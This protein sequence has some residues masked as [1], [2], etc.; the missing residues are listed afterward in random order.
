MMPDTI[1]RDVLIHAPQAR[2]WSALTEAR[3]L[4]S[5]F[6]DAGAEVELRL[7]GRVRIDWREHGTALG[8]VEELDPPHAFGFR[9]SLIS[10]EPPVPGNSTLVRFTLEPEGD[11]H[12]RLR[13]VESGFRSLDGDATE[14]RR[15]LEANEA[16]W[17]A[18]LEELR[19]YLAPLR[20]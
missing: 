4:G 5:W 13:V 14:R 6:G 9:W 20:R 11:E 7:G 19:G 1:E 18:E 10:D 15:H 17:R 12:T 16:G 8:V 3:H 2:V